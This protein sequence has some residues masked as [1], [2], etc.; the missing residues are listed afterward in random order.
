MP[1]YQYMTSK[2]INF[3]EH[4]CKNEEKLAKIYVIRKN[5]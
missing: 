2:K 4:F 5:Y 1:V 3:F